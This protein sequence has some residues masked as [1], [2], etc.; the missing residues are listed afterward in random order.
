MAD[1]KRASSFT[2]ANQGQQANKYRENLTIL[3]HQT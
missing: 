2:L 1:L 3:F